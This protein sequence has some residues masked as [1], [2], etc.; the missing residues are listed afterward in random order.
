MVIYHWLLALKA[1]K[2]HK[3]IWFFNGKIK[4]L[5]GDEEGTSY[6]YWWN[7]FSEWADWWQQLENCGYYSVYLRAA[8]VPAGRR[9]RYWPTSTQCGEKCFI[10]IEVPSQ[11]SAIS[12]LPRFLWLC[13][14]L[15]V[16][17]V[18]PCAAVHQPCGPSASLLAPSLS[19]PALASGPQN[20]WCATEHWPRHLF[21]QQFAQVRGKKMI[22]DSN[23]VGLFHQNKFFLC[24]AV[25]LWAYYRSFST[26]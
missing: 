26:E 4:S 17:S 16:F 19:L 2:T 5:P 1:N 6:V 14:Q 12:P 24:V 18:D 21:H 13:Q 9:S 11:H 20:R 7:F 10:S 23:R 22:R 15:A 3:H 8:Q 25:F